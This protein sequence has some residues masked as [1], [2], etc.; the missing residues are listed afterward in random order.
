[1]LLAVVGGEVEMVVEIEMA[2]VGPSS[3]RCMRPGW[4]SGRGRAKK[5]KG[6]HTA[7]AT[8]RGRAGREQRATCQCAAKPRQASHISGHVLR[9]VRALGAR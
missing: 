1:M 3:R 6:E 4:I 8:A 5:K 9:V 2:V 7:R